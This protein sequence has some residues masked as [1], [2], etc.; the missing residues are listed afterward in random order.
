[1]REIDMISL[2]TYLMYLIDVVILQAAGTYFFKDYF[3]RNR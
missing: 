3:K 1:M 2:F